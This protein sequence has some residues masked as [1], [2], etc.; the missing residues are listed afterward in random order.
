MRPRADLFYRINVFSLSIPPLRERP[1]DVRELLDYFIEKYCTHG[2]LGIKKFD[3]ESMNFLMNY[4]W[5]GNVREL[6]NIVERCV[7]TS[8]SSII[9]IYNLPKYTTSENHQIPNKPVSDPVQE[10]RMPRKSERERIIDAL[11]ANDGVVKK[12]AEDLGFDRRTL[13]RKA[14]K[15]EI[16]LTEYRN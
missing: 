4:S 12:A 9:T 14:K 16:D 3:S 5:P 1:G 10:I 2:N 13:Y 15:H 11:I 8:T 7:Y 6:E